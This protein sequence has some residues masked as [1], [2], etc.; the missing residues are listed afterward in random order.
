MGAAGEAKPTPVLPILIAMVIGAA[1]GWATGPDGALGGVQLLP[2][3]DTIGTMF[4]NLLKMLIVPLILASVITGVASLGSGPDLG[5][6][7]G[8]TLGFYVITTLIAVLIALLLVNLIE[9]GV[10]DGEPQRHALA[11]TKDAG[12]VAAGVKAHAESSV[13]DSIK[14]IVPANMVDAALNT[15]MIG[16]VL[17]SIL[18]GFFLARIA[19]PYRDNVYGFWHGLFLIMMRMTGF[20]MWLAPIGVFGLIAKVVAVSGF[21]AGHSLLLF[22]AS[23]LGGLLLYGFV[24]LPVLLALV[25]RVNPW[26]LYPAMA[27]ALLTAFSTA[28]SSATL[29]LSL[30]CLEERAKVS[31]RIAGFV[32]PLGASMNHA[33]S[34]LY[35]C[36][37][38]MFIAQAYGLHLSFATQFTVVILALV[39]SMGMA[40]IPAASLVGIAVILAAVGLPA[41]AIGVLLVFDRLLDM[42]RTAINVLAD[43]CCAVIVARLEGETAVLSAPVR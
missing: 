40:G 30:E 4:I 20:V 43:S 7:G 5:R 27:P 41:E 37:A 36:A 26:R 15:R 25:A 23:V 3:F 14:G 13:L 22:A 8:K 19:Q 33:G 6:L 32:M 17:F 9:P 29:P 11:L 38:A 10:I 12:E 35:E 21:E 42:C 1:V 39:T 28:S 24:A 31:P 18:F 2:V 16:L 34:A